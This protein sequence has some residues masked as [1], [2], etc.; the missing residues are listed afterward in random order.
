MSVINRNLNNRALLEKAAQVVGDLAPGGLLNEQQ[1]VDFLVLAIKG[2]KI[3]PLCTS[4]PMSKPKQEIDKL[5][6]DD[7]VLFPGT[8]VTALDA[9]DESKASF[10]R[11]TLDV[12]T[13]KGVTRMSDEVLEDNIMKDGLQDYLL[14]GMAKKVSQDMENLLIN[15]DTALTGLLGTFDGIIKQATSNV[16]IAG[17]VALDKT[18][19]KNTIKTLPEQYRNEAHKMGFFTSA[20]AVLD[21]RSTVADRLTSL[22]DAFLTGNGG[23]QFQ[24]TDVHGVP[25]F[26]NA[27]GADTDETVLLYMD[28]KNVYVGAYKEI[29]LESDRNIETCVTTYVVRTRW[30]VKYAEEPRV[31]KATGVLAG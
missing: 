14:R 24:A 22:G 10:Q 30:D 16:Y 12:K 20:N 26:P 6:W 8:E 19:L 5:L 11:V 28:P 1:S 31:V 3:L 13:L 25:M 23:L 15:G 2:A 21:Y 18:V 4:Q 27:L 9:A 7:Q 17:G 29:R